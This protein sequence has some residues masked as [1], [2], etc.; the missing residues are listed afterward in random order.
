MFV[1]GRGE[2][3]KKG[4]CVQSKKGSNFMRVNWKRACNEILAGNIMGRYR[5]GEPVKIGG[6]IYLPII[7]RKNYAERD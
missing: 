1:S 7:T 4:R 6:E 2:T 5:V 3:S